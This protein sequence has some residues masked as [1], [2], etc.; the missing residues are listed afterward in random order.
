MKKTLFTFIGILAF[1]VV[2]GQATAEA[3]I[4]TTLTDYIEGSSYNKVDQIKKAFADNATL[5]LTNKEGEFKIYSP[6]QYT[7]F[8]KNG[9]VGKFNGRVGKILDIDIDKDIATARAEIAIPARETRY[10][11]L[12]LLK[13][14]EG[15]GWK[16]ISK[17]ATQTDYSGYVPRDKKLDNFTLQRLLVLNDAGEIL[18]EQGEVATEEKEATWFPLSVYSNTRQSVTEAMDSLALSRGIKI[19]KPELRAY[20]TYKFTYHGQASFRSYFVAKYVSGD[21]NTPTKALTM[22]WLPV[23]EAL[24]HIP[25]E[26]IRLITK[27]VLEFPESLWGGSFLISENEELHDTRVLEEFYPLFANKP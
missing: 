25:V 27:Q 12:F 9:E 23:E 16:I 13:N 11:D 6:E 17:T 15:Q 19:S 3:L 20:T 2:H 1:T 8:F 7:G 22:K 21:L 5:Y 4:R 26:A 14:I 10:I 18:M 24:S